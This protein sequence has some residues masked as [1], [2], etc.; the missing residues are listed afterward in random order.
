M[1]NDNKIKLG[2]VAIFLIV[3]ILIFFIFINF[4]NK[5]VPSNSDHYNMSEVTEYS[6]FFA[7][8]NNINNYLFYNY[9][10]DADAILANLHPTY[11]SQNNLNRNNILA[12]IPSFSDSPTYQAKN[13]YY[14]ENGDIYT[15]YVIGDIL[16]NNYE[17]TTIFKE[18]QKYLLIVDYNTFGIQ[19]YP[20]ND[21]D[22]LTTLPFDVSNIS[23]TK[24]NYN[25]FKSSK[26][27]TDNYICN[28]YYAQFYSLLLNDLDKS[29]NL[30]KDETKN[31]YPNLT[32]YR[33]YFKDNIEKISPQITNCE[34]TTRNSKRI[35][36]I[37]DALNN[38]F[39]FEETSIMNYQVNFKL[40]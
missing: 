12:N 19:I 2:I 30:L 10:K 22:N 38:S 21:S 14:Q 20:L 8:V 36:T 17:D 40:K 24:N 25:E 28:L 9:S 6:M 1:S 23:I 29:Y 11:I 18:N 4:N 27:I 26:L 13:M 35:Y 16:I 34:S 32:E 3:V 15:F 33:Q 37:T 5:K 31:R 7:V 39:T